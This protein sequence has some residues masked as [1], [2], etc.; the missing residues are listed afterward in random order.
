MPDKREESFDF[1]FPRPAAEIRLC[2]FSGSPCNRTEGS[3]G[4]SRCGN[5]VIG[6]VDFTAGPSPHSP[7]PIRMKAAGRRTWH[8]VDGIYVVGVM[9]AAPRKQIKLLLGLQ[10]WRC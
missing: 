9:I 8:A 6:G 1:E 3:G 2:H 10:L 7:F 5:P 4:G